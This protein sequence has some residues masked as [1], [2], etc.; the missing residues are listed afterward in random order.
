ML[1]DKAHREECMLSNK[2]YKK[3]TMLSDKHS[4]ETG[5]CDKLTSDWRP[6]EHYL[7]FIGDF[8][9]IVKTLLDAF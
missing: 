5:L 2:V 3:E 9:N 7:T 4:E 8:L 1:S 6:S